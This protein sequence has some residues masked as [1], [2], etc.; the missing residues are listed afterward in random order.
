MTSHLHFSQNCSKFEAPIMTCVGTHQNCQAENTCSEYSVIRSA[1][2][3]SELEI[4][5]TKQSNLDPG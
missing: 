3:K 2:P 5:Q 4:E 1:E